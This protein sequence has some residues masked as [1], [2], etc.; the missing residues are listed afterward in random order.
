MVLVAQDVEQ[1]RP[2]IA[3]GALKRL[4]ALVLASCVVI[5]REAAVH[6]AALVAELVAD[7]AGDQGDWRGKQS[8]YA[9]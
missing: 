1:A 6:D 4:P 7:V 3:V 2:R 9:Y 5:L 8:V